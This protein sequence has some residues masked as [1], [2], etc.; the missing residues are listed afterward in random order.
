MS[1]E[2]GVLD[3]IFSRITNYYGIEINSF[4]E[5]KLGADKD[6]HTYKIGN[7]NTKYFLKIRSGCF[8]TLSIV[9]PNFL[10]EEKNI[11]NIIKPIKTLDGKLYI[12][13]S[14]FHICLYPFVMGNDCWNYNFSEVQWNIF[15]NVLYSIHNADFPT[16]IL[17]KLPKE[18]YGSQSRKYVHNMLTKIEER[19]EILI[20]EYIEFLTKRK[21]IIYKL[22]DN[23]ENK[24][25]EVKMLQQNNCV[26]HGD[27]HAG[28]IMVSEDGKLFLVDWDTII[29]SPKERDLMFIGGGI[30]N[31]WNTI[32]EIR[33]FYKGYKN[34]MI[35]EEIVSYYRFERII[36]DIEEYDY[37]LI[38]PSTNRTDKIN[39]VNILESQFDKDNVV[40]M[41]FKTIKT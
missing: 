1:I 5:L 39:I 8:N 27:I 7:G 26:C 30:G 21:D 17:N 11:E 24:S 35:N 41:A 2:D 22:I 9:I 28:N 4:E 16:N 19:K 36:K 15:G 32:D 10:A 23:A 6:T 12:R 33:N 18:N 3:T 20:K 31:K 14:S 13:Y 38:A 40:D 37:Q 29:Y 34:S 25:K